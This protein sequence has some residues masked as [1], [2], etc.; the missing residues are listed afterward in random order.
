MLWDD[1]PI[2]MVFWQRERRWLWLR[3]RFLATG[4]AAVLGL[5]LLVW[6]LQFRA[7]EIWLWS[8]EF[9]LWIMMPLCTLGPMGQIARDMKRWRRQSRLADLL[10]TPLPGG[11]YVRGF[12]FPA[13]APLALLFLITWAGLLVL[14]PVY[15]L[16]GRG[17]SYTNIDDILPIVLFSPLYFLLQ[18]L[19][20]GTITLRLCIA[21]RSSMAG[22]TLAALILIVAPVA[23]SLL[24]GQLFTSFSGFV[25]WMVLLG[26]VKLV[27][28]LALLS[29]MAREFPNQVNV[30]E[31]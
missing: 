26:F 18:L 20:S 5:G 28:T 3:S 17:E 4:I 11:D 13:V 27:I 16:T 22:E 19:W 24:V 23:P 7:R 9:Y 25:A 30:A 14:G 10:I 29:N 8:S 31:R 15:Q 6:M 2:L 1:N 21:H 12:L